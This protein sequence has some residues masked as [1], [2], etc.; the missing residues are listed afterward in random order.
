MLSA[1]AIVSAPPTLNIEPPKLTIEETQR[2]GW[3]KKVKPPSMVLDEDINGFKA[4]QNKKHR[5]GKGKGK[6]VSGECY[7]FC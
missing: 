2:D 3:G 4:S 7:N 1:T 6:K 5:G